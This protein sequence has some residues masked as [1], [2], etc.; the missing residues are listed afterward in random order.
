MPP[1]LRAEQ[2]IKGLEANGY[3]RH[4][5]RNV[6]YRSGKPVHRWNY[7]SNIRMATC[8]NNIMYFDKLVKQVCN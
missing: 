4:T 1:V 5:D 6:V 8:P 3:Y 7:V 2:V